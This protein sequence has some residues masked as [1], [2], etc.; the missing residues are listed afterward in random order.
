MSLT[1]QQPKASKIDKFCLYTGAAFPF[2]LITGNSAFE[3]VVAL[4]GLGWLVGLCVSRRNPYPDLL[5]DPLVLP[6]IVW[7]GTMVLSLLING[8]G[9]KG[10]G[11]DI[12]LF[13]QLLFMTA[14]LD[15]SRRR[16]VIKPLTIGL[17][18]GTSWAAINLLAAYLIGHDLIGNSLAQHQSKIFLTG[19]IGAVTA[20]AS[21]LFCCYALL[22]KKEPIKTRI[23]ALV[24]GL[25]SLFQLNHTHVRT[26]LI[27]SFLGLTTCLLW[28]YAKRFSKQN[29]AI[30]GLGLAILSGVAIQ[31][32]QV[33]QI[34]KNVNLESMYDRVMIWKVTTEMWQDKPFWG[35]GVSS[36]R[37]SYKE[38]AATFP[39]NF[40][41]M[42]S[43]TKIPWSKEATHAHN[44]P[45]MLLACTGIPGIMAFSWLFLR[46]AINSIQ[47]QNQH[48][49]VIA[50]LT[51]FIIIGLT[52]YNIYHSWYIS[53]FAYLATMAGS[54]FQQKTTSV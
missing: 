13:R 5:K 22:R 2:A 29:L 42:Q 30:T 27:A 52:G 26:T 32:T 51:V 45:L 28:Q 4:V 19:R 25:I 33:A 49:E 40:I 15:I 44:I 3:A 18:I 53:L 50:I 23:L 54:L 48:P 17:A 24:I 39:E 31:S 43:G 1:S 9:S 10:W 37:D 34:S 20:Y 38:K 16:P 35:T 36:F 47:I 41:V 7:Y 11:H 14:L 6:W 8:P 46:L 12:V 21:S